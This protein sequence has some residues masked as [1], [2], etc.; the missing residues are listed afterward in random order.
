VQRLLEEA[1]TK[2]MG[3]PVGVHLRSSDEL[4]SILAHNPFPGVAGNRV[5]VLFLESAPPA[6][7]LAG[8][9]NPSNE[10]M[11]LSGREVFIHYPDGMGKSKLKIPFAKTATARNLNT[12]EKLLE[13]S[14]AI[15]D[16]AVTGV[17]G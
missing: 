2:K 13:L 15:C 8:I 4:A 6:G 16:Q 14:R 1:L 7:A 5:I 12:V 10:E 9:Q 11:R 3:K 17:P